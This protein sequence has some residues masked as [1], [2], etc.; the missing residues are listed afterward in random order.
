MEVGVPKE[1]VIA[2]ID[3]D[4][5]A[6]EGTMDLIEAMGF[7]AKSFECAEDFLKSAILQKYVVLDHGRANARYDRA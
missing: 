7:V 6:R 5:S 2:I 3:D 4:R 1:T